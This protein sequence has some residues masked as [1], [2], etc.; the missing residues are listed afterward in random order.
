MA[1]AEEV[2]EILSGKIPS[3]S[4]MVSTIHN[5]DNVELYGINGHGFKIPFTE[6]DK[7]IEELEGIG[8]NGDI[9]LTKEGFEVEIP[10]NRI[11]KAIF[12]LKMARDVGVKL[13]EYAQIF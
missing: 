1:S 4:M 3:G 9:V 2:A 13:G 5:S 7:F 6:L 10:R 8:G 12:Y 11:Q